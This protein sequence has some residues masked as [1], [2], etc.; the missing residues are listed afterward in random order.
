M[1]KSEITY[2]LNKIIEG[3]CLATLKEIPSDSV[4]VGVTFPLYNKC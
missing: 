2:W 4:D 1:R 3:D